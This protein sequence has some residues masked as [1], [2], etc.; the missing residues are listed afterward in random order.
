M[1]RIIVLSLFLTVVIGCYPPSYY[2]YRDV[3]SSER[4]PDWTDRYDYYSPYTY[5]N[6]FYYYPYLYFPFS[7]SFNYSYDRYNFDYPHRFHNYNRNPD[8]GHR[9]PRR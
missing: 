3:P 7:F 1:L 9:Y 8:R 4:Y 6:P 2:G 5:Y